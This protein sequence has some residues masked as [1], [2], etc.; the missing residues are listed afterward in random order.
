LR[1]AEG[2]EQTTTFSLKVND[3][4]GSGTITFIASANGKESRLRSTISVR[5]PATYL[6]QVRSSNFTKNSVDVPVTRSMY[7]EFRKSTAAV[8]ALPLGLAHGLDAYLKDFPHGCSFS[9][10]KPTSV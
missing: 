6:T 2:H 1:V 10:M 8:S 5:P 7:P 9:P 3:K 4:L